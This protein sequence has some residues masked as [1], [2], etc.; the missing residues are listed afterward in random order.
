MKTFALRGG[1]LVIQSGGYAMATGHDKIHQ[2]LRGAMLEPV[3]N[4]RFHPAFGS[5]IDR[6]IGGI[7]DTMTA[8][9]VRQEVGRILSNYVAIQQDRISRDIQQGTK[10]RFL[11]SEVIANIDD[12][13]VDIVADS[14]SLT[15]RIRTMEDSSVTLTTEVGV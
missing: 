3:G 6:F 15:V 10:S 5:Q 11:A 13:Q 2:D 1:D 14:V 9:K 8:F 12:I 7:A 4:D